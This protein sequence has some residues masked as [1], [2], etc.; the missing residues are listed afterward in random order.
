MTKDDSE[1]QRGGQPCSAERRGKRRAERSESEAALGL[2]TDY[3]EVQRAEKAC[4]A[5]RGYAHANERSEMSAGL[6]CKIALLIEYLGKNFCGSQAQ[7]NSRTVQSV[8]E[9]ALNVWLRPPK[10]VKVVL[11]G[12]TDS[13]VHAIGQ[14]AHFDLPQGYLGHGTLDMQALCWGVNGIL[15]TDLSLRAAAFVDPAF[16]ARFSANERKYIYRILNQKQRSPF[17]K[18]THYFIR[19]PLIIE[20][21]QQAINFLPGSHDFAA[22]KSSNSDRL[23][24]VCSVSHAQLLHLGEGEL[25]FSMTANHFL[26]NMIRI[27]VGTLVEI[28]LNKRDVQSLKIALEEGKRQ[29]AGPTAPPWGLC[30]VSVKYPPPYA[31]MFSLHSSICQH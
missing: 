22:F 28:G 18:D 14:V 12:R 16:H 30:L 7:K 5:E 4:A 10:P 8:L 25:E 19:Q 27:I 9:E 20:N 17:F 1:A 3:S 23:T 15:P 11:S 24:T 29:L 2:K 13:G 6:K 26:Y 21:M 31:N